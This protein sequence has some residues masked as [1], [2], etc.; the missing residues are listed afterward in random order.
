MLVNKGGV[1][2]V[3]EKNLNGKK[4]KKELLCKHR[5]PNAIG[6]YFEIWA[7]KICIGGRSLFSN[8]TVISYFFSGDMIQINS[9]LQFKILSSLHGPNENV[10]N[11]SQ[12]VTSMNHCRMSSMF[13]SVFDLKLL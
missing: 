3:C 11:I 6:P 2:I 7:I 13:Q 9:L 1:L 8:S 5:N 12:T 10:F 4:P